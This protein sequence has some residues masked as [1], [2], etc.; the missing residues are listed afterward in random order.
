MSATVVLFV[1]HAQPLTTFLA[2]AKQ[3][4]SFM[5]KTRMMFHQHWFSFCAAM[6]VLCLLTQNPQNHQLTRRQ[7]LS[8]SHLQHE[9]V[10]HLSFLGKGITTHDPRVSFPCYDARRSEMRA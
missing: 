4:A 5:R 10:I 6:Q 9:G 1:T 7:E 8:M 2:S 3:T